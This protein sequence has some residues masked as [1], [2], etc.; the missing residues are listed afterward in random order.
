MYSYRILKTWFDLG[1]VLILSRTKN[2]DKDTDPG[3]CLSFGGSMPKDQI[4]EVASKDPP[5]LGEI[6]LRVW[7]LNQECAWNLCFRIQ[8]YW[9]NLAYRWHRLSWPMH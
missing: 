2:Y 9:K 4:L 6:G 3:I 1:I 8:K 5:Y 7:E